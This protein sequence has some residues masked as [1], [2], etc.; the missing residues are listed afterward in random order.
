M[1][2][3]QVTVIFLGLFVQEFST[4]WRSI[5]TVFA[6]AVG[7][8]ESDTY[9]NHHNPR[10]TV[11]LLVLYLFVVT[12]IMLNL[13]IALLTNAQEKVQPL[14][15]PQFSSYT[16]QCCDPSMGCSVSVI[17]LG[18]SSPAVHCVPKPHQ[19]IQRQ[20]HIFLSLEV[21]KCRP[22]VPGRSLKVVR[23]FACS[24]PSLYCSGN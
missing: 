10:L 3:Q 2:P 21:S 4:L 13:L 17:C 19:E 15:P 12:V 18:S 7:E 9:I 11:P 6:A 24:A 14:L 8:F 23:L 5:Y 1:A 16:L 20:Y 22:C